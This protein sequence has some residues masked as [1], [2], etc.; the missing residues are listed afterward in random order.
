MGMYECLLK[1]CFS[2][3]KVALYEARIDIVLNAFLTSADMITDVWVLSGWITD[4]PPEMW[5]FILGLIFISLSDL[6]SIGSYIILKKFYGQQITNWGLLTHSTGFGPF[7]DG[8]VLWKQPPEYEELTDGSL[9][10]KKEYEWKYFMYSRAVES[11][12]EA[13]PFTVLQGYVMVKQQKYTILSLVSITLS[14]ICAGLPVSEH[15][16][17][18]VALHIVEVVVFVL[19]WA[20]DITVR[21]L[22]FIYLIIYRLQVAT[23]VGAVVL[24][25]ETFLQFFFSNEHKYGLGEKAVIILRAF[26]GVFLFFGSTVK[27]II[28]DSRQN[29]IETIYR[30]SLSAAIAIYLFCIEVIKTW[31]LGCFIAVVVITGPIQVYYYLHTKAHDGRRL[32]GSILLK[33]VSKLTGEGNANPLAGIDSLQE[34]NPEIEATVI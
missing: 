1:L 14:Y 9:V 10:M 3:E 21:T 32:H 11:A 15:I 12:F 24:T 19:I 13:I 25:L 2:K 22:P 16:G 20:G 4:D 6:I 34:K 31:Q 7:Y 8:I 29:A 28:G 33:D 27:L 17:C 26:R 23:I 18:E 30:F 5:C